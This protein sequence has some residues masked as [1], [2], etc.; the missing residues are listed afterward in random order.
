[1]RRTAPTAD[2]L[3]DAFEQVATERLLLRRPVHDD[4]GDLHR[5]HSDP[6]TWEHLPGSRHGRAQSGRR[7]AHWLAHWEARGYGYWS[8]ERGGRIVGFGGL[9]LLLGW[10][11]RDALNLYYRLEPESWGHG[12]ASELAQAAVRLAGRELPELLVV[13]RIRDGNERSVRVAE[14]AG[15]VRRADLDDD[16]YLAYA[17]A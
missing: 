11:G 7:L 8:V 2:R 17:S 9:M 6:R 13:A 1:M 12:Y 3:S 15:L 10:R 5:I 16:E 4:L 14:R